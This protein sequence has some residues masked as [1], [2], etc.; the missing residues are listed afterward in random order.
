M[1]SF[2]NRLAVSLFTA[3]FFTITAM[4]AFAD[5]FGSRFTIDIGPTYQMSGTGDAA[6]PPPAGYGGVGYTNDHP[7]ANSAQL[8]YGADVVLDKNTHLYYSH[9]VLFFNIGRIL[10]LAPKTS[11]VFGSFY[12]RTD[13]VGI[14]HEFGKTGVLG[15]LYYYD[16]ARMDVS[17]LCNNQIDCPNAAGVQSGNPA[18]IDEHGYG[19]GANYNFGPTT[20]IGPLFTLVADAKYVPRSDVDPTGPCGS[21]EGIGHYVGSQFIFPYSLSMKLPFAMSHTFIPFVGIGRDVNLFRDETTQ[22][23]YN[24]TNFGIVKVINK[25]LVF[26][27]V[28]INYA[29]CRCTDTIPPPDNVRLSAILVKLDIKTKL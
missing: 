13:T 29:G 14:N 16:H 8:E 19:I 6:A 25:N 5:D 4:P 15:R 9:N 22:E 1:R 11:F 24:T 7:I 26:S 23:M 3:I 27:A 10:T 21:C 2:P 20:R 17:G 28:D 12:D 18:S